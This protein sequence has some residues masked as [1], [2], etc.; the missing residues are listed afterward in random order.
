[1]EHAGSFPDESLCG[2]FC[3]FGVAR[4]AMLGGPGLGIRLPPMTH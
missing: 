2:T 3:G 1:M 4:V